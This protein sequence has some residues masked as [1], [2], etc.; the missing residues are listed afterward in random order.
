VVFHILK[1]LT[2]KVLVKT[3][4]STICSPSVFYDLFTCPYLNPLS[5]SRIKAAVQNLVLLSRENVTFIVQ[6]F[7]HPLS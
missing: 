3:K 2:F 6:R 4:D 1:T 5:R 7:C